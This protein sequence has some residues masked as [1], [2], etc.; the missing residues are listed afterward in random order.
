[1]ARILKAECASKRRKQVGPVDHF[2]LTLSAWVQVWVT[3]DLLLLLLSKVQPLI[4]LFVNV[5]D[6]GAALVLFFYLLELFL[7]GNGR[8]SAKSFIVYVFGLLNI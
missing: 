4:L 2:S 1:M 5:V 6:E 7:P 3:Q 8:E